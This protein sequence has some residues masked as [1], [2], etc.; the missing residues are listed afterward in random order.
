MTS[1]KSSRASLKSP[2]EPFASVSLSAVQKARFKQHTSANRGL[3]VHCTKQSKCGLKQS[4]VLKLNGEHIPLVDPTA[5]LK[6]HPGLWGSSV[7][8]LAVKVTMTS[9]QRIA[10]VIPLKQA[11]VKGTLCAVCGIMLQRVL[12][13]KKISSSI[14][15]VVGL[16]SRRTSILTLLPQTLRR[17]VPQKQTRGPTCAVMWF[18]S[19]LRVHDNEALNAAA[20]AAAS[21]ACV[22]E[23]P[24]CLDSTHY[25]VN[26]DEKTATFLGA[27][28]LPI[29]IFDPRMYE[30][31]SSGFGRNT[32]ERSAFLLESVSALR[33]TLRVKGSELMVQVGHTEEV[34]REL[35]RKLKGGTQHRESLDFGGGE[36]GLRVEVY[37]QAGVSYE[38]VQE[39]ERVRAVLGS[40]GAE[41]MVH[42]GSTLYHAQ[43]MPFSSCLGFR[44]L[45]HD[46]PFS[47]ADSKLA[48]EAPS[49]QASR[50]IKY[51]GTGA[52]YP[53]PLPHKDHP[54]LGTQGSNIN[55]TQKAADLPSIDKALTTAT[56]ASDNGMPSSYSSFKQLLSDVSIRFPLCP[57]SNMIAFP[58]ALSNSDGIRT[59][60][61]GLVASNI[62]TLGN[63][64]GLDQLQSGFTSPQILS[65]H[66]RDM[67]LFASDDANRIHNALEEQNS[68]SPI[69]SREACPSLPR[70]ALDSNAQLCGGETAA[71]R[72]LQNILCRITGRHQGST[73]QGSTVHAGEKQDDA[74]VPCTS[75]ATTTR[76]GRG[77][78]CSE[79]TAES[80]IHFRVPAA[81]AFSS[82]TMP[83]NFR[84][85][86]FSAAT[87]E[88][89]A[90][91]GNLN[92][93][94][95]CLLSPWL[96][97]GCLSPRLVHHELSKAL[98]VQA[99][100]NHE[101][102][103]PDLRQ[104]LLFELQW[105]DFFTF[106]TRKYSLMKLSSVSK[107]KEKSVL[108]GMLC[109]IP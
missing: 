97:L 40:E 33:E 15:K 95:Q 67:T 5:A 52:A 91:A 109:P 21:C 14:S 77:V 98:H 4:T 28:L 64:P 108:H 72:Q 50:G 48:Q 68:T 26:R 9:L 31:A 7:C 103:Q 66:Q 90:A 79:S 76:E 51:S 100:L 3:G 87:A 37:C 106:M 85:M 107:E 73:H 78:D 96:S 57:P 69:S 94:L 1:E 20:A 18:R 81:A 55:T 61:E 101:V 34:L 41:L 16:S 70:R 56:G 59:T 32:P 35:V 75:I 43:D 19:D 25:E 102:S 24:G 49:S 53:S 22:N 12:M 8:K 83:L 80:P 23:Q 13:S 36:T 44:H 88:A 38:D 105:R 99:Q 45:F 60:A 47:D 86:P 93:S 89:G 63:I 84:G 39:E 74:E 82:S 29:Y 54:D 71:L 6:Q 2:M 92:S 62:L 11:L 10:A 42:W 30:R 104:W 58:P 17:D 46:P 65:M 27:G